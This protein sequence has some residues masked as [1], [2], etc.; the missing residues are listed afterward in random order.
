MSELARALLGQLDA[1]DLAVLAQR[2][3]PFLPAPEASSDDAWL[4]TRQAAD[5]AGTTT[6]ALHKAMRDGK[7]AFEQAAPG[8]KA[9]FRRGDLDAWRRGA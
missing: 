6:H 4:T 9:W 2:L 1:D 7:V 5:Y 8:C 3:A